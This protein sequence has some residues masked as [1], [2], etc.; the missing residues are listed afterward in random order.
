MKRQIRR[1]PPVQFT[2]AV[3]DEPLFVRQLSA[4]QMSSIETRNPVDEEGQRDSYG[5]FAGVMAEACVDES[6]APIWTPDELQTMDAGDFWQLWDVVG[7]HLGIKR[8]P[9]KNSQPASG[10]PESSR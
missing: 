3:C 4:L 5:F 7:R 10:S 2:V 1:K 9:A 8:T 6:G